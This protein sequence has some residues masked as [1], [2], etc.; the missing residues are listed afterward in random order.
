M[1]GNWLAQVRQVLLGLSPTAPE[2]WGAVEAAATNQYHRWLMSEP[3]DRLALDPGVISA[4]FDRLRYQRVESRAVSLILAAIPQN[5]RDEAVSN[6]WL[7]SE[8]LIF[9]IQC[10]YQPGGA[11][12][13]SMLLSFVVAPDAMKQLSQACTILRKWQQWI[14]RIQEL[15]ASLPDASLLLRG[16]DQAAADLLAEHPAIAFRVNSFRHRVSIDHNPTVG[17]VCQLVR[18]LQAEFEAAALTAG[19][20]AEKKAKLA[21]MAPEEP[22]GKGKG[23]AA[24]AAPKGPDGGQKDSPKTHPEGQR[25]ENM[26]AFFNEGKGCKLGDACPNFHNKTL[27]RKQNRCLGCGQRNHYRSDCTVAPQPSEG[28][29]PNPGGKQGG[30]PKGQKGGKGGEPA[31][32]AADASTA[33]PQAKT[34][35]ETA[36]AQSNLQPSQQQLISEA[37]QLLKSLHVKRLSVCAAF[38]RALAESPTTGGCRGLLDS[39]AT[40]GLRQ[41]T[42]SEIAE[43]R[44]IEVSLAVGSRKMAIT[45]HGILLVAEPIQPIVPMHYLTELG[46]RVYW[47]RKR[48]KVI[49]PSRQSPEV[50]VENGSPTVA[51]EDAYQLLRDYEDL[52]C[53]RAR[54]EAEASI[55]AKAL[56]ASIQDPQGWL[57]DTLN[58]GKLGPEARLAWLRSVFPKVADDDLV[59]ASGICSTRASRWNRRWRRSMERATCVMVRLGLKARGDFQIA[60]STQVVSCS[61]ERE[62]DICEDSVFASLL[63]LAEQGRIGGF[64]GA[65]EDQDGKG[66]IRFLRLSLLHALASAS[67]RMF[68]ASCPVFFA[69]TQTA[70]GAR[71]LGEL[72]TPSFWDS[73][74]VRSWVELNEGYQARFDKGSFG[75]NVIGPSVMLTNSWFLWEELHE[76]LSEGLAANVTRFGWDRLRASAQPVWPPG[77]WKPVHTALE[78]WARGSGRLQSVR[79]GRQATVPFGKGAN[80]C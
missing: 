24:N 48:C 60:G 65:F 22:K 20:S 6:R 55:L 50:I 61:I 70:V 25:K 12:E 9:R 45:Q 56:G 16:I 52:Q 40:N 27:A 77:M 42:P 66:I 31:V 15:R 36:A 47:K 23:G 73:S 43:S 39:G 69:V 35:I 30:K 26:C 59:S 37:T 72:E 10:V 29:N 8:A 54:I 1:A 58:R 79:G 51:E 41:G 67:D 76:V 44:T 78:D 80:V 17:T 21:A 4:N 2:W 57:R 3:I 53:K 14:L 74:E 19:E 46:Y 34:V 75:A 49:H 18:L 11:S 13:R 32:R 7:S 28:L 63:E 33:S 64:V 5:L 68:N 62:T 71:D 38:K